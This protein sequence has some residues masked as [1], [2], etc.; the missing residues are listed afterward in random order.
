MVREPRHT[1]ILRTTRAN[2]G[3]WAVYAVR[4]E[5]NSR[6]KIEKERISSFA[7]CEDEEGNR[8][9]SGVQED[10]ELCAMRED[11]VGHFSVKKG[12]HKIREAAERFVRAKEQEKGNLI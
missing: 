11:F 2:G 10:G 8:F 9:V 12:R 1:K 7:L 3:W 4:G 5:N 6:A